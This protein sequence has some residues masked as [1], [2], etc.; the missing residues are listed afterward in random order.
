MY[1]Y[2]QLTVNKLTSQHKFFF[3]SN[4]VHLFGLPHTCASNHTLYN[5]E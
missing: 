2:L 3:T 1:R 4:T 5:P